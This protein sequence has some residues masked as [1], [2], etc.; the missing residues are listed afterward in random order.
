MLKNFL[1]FE[2]PHKSCFLMFGVLN[3]K[4]L[5]FDTPDE[6]VLTIL[7]PFDKNLG[8]HEE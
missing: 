7:S 6:N 8:I 2:T 5:A 3:A 4:N 1:A